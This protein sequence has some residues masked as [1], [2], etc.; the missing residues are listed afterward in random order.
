MVRAVLC[1]LLL[2]LVGLTMS[3]PIEETPLRAP[4]ANYRLI[5]TSDQ[6]PPFW[7][8]AEAA[9]ALSTTELSYFDITD[10]PEVDLSL[11][12]QP[13]AIPAAPT[14]QSIVTPLLARIDKTRYSTLLTS[15]STSF[16]NRYYSA[17]TGLDSANWIF[18]QVSTVAANRSDIT[19]SKFAHTWLQPSIIAKIAGTSGTREIVILGAH[20]DSTA[21]GMPTGSAPGA[22]D[23]GSGSIA[24]LEVFRIL[25]EANFRPQH[26]IEFHWYSA[27]EVG[28]LGSQ[29]VA[30]NYQSQGIPVRSMIQLDMIAYNRLESTVGIV[31]D[32]VDA[33]TIAFNRRLVDEYLAIGWTNT[34]CGYGCSDHASWNR[35]G[36]RSSFPFEA[37]FS[38]RNPYIHTTADTMNYVSVDHAAEFIKLGLAFAVELSYV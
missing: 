4:F 5:S 32:Y 8:S 28:L 23:D 17:Q 30:V 35:L 1:V 18:N 21:A 27:E 25:V 7:V 20:E 37:Q 15:L 16:R 26:P 11:T 3:R 2:A 9:E 29:A 36:Y 19:V 33:D 10:S 6:T 38:R 24:I 13:S 31:T 22:D 34:V 12:P 14:H